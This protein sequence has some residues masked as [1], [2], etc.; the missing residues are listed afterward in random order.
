[1]YLQYIS[2]QYLIMK[3]EERYRPK[4]LNAEMFKKAQ[5]RIRVRVGF[6]LALVY[7]CKFSCLL[8][9]VWTNCV[10][11]IVVIKILIIHL[12]VFIYYLG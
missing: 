7:A 5:N 6:G 12:H 9:F 3:S 2:T 10:L 8:S 11:S 4:W 1:M